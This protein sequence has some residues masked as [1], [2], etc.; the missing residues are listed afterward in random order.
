[1]AQDNIYPSLFT[2]H[3]TF[4]KEILNGKLNF[5]RSVYQIRCELH[6]HGLLTYLLF[7]IIFGG[8]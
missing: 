6:L 5:F 2:L 7:L 4:T 8:C 3:Y 1:M